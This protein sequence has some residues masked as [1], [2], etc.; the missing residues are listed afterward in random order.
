MLDGDGGIALLER[1]SPRERE[2]PEKLKKEAMKEPPNFFKYI[3]S[4]EKD[5]K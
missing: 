5:N 2:E 4:T 3:Q 1:L